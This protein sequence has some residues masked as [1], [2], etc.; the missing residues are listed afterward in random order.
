MLK[1]CVS[2]FLQGYLN[3]IV[4]SLI[5]VVNRSEMENKICV[6]RSS[7][8]TDKIRKIPAAGLSNA[9]PI[10]RVLCVHGRLGGPSLPGPAWRGVAVPRDTSQQ[11]HQLML[12][13]PPP[14]RLAHD[15]S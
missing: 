11:S 13:P 1:V 9:H 6:S 10:T 3:K 5:C 8:S 7:S 15:S 14:R 12:P 2:E 4:L